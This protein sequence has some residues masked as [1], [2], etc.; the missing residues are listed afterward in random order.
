MKTVV[1]G[2]G[3]PILGD[4]GVGWKVAEEVK[5]QIPLPRLR[6]LS[7]TGREVREISTWVDAGIPEK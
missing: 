1:I 6:N 3:N 5:R 7:P 4:D 2:L